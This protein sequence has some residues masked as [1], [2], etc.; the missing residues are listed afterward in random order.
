MNGTLKNAGLHRTEI[1][2]P[3]HTVFGGKICFSDFG[4]RITMAEMAERI[5][6]DRNF[7]EQCR[8]NLTERQY[9]ES[10]G[11]SESAN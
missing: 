9:R 6:T 7:N 1:I 10:H 11:H 5:I 4:R 3:D 8:K 2:R